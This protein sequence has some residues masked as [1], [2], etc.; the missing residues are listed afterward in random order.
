MEAPEPVRRRYAAWSWTV[1]YNAF[2]HYATTWRL[3]H[4]DGG[5][6]YLK[7][8]D[9]NAYPGA[10]AEAARMR[11]AHR[12]LPVPEVL[13]SGGDA[14]A[15]WLVTAPVGGRD[16]N[17]PELRGDPGRL[18]DLLGAGLRRFHDAAPVR[19]CPFDFRLDTAMAHARSRV[20]GGIVA[21]DF[22]QEFAYL[23]PTDALAELERLRPGSED[24]V[25]CHGDYCPPNVLVD[26][27]EVS[28]FVDLG[29]LG[30]ADR[31]RDLARG[32]WSVTWT[33]GPGLETRFYRAYGDVTPDPD[34]VRFYRL[35][36]D[37]SA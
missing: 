20:R 21:G 32:S 25:V 11:W 9:A 5:V 2:P 19:D 24:L 18:V 27:G 22:V 33:Y 8:V 36:S 7:V 14:V 35:L 30:V 37:L 23:S 15:A 31:W 16:A 3:R 1:A 29:E 13:E 12:Y 17:S 10:V 34:R 4:P 6:R 26:G 28:G